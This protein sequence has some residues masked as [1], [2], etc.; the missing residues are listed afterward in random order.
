MID[1][2]KE[3]V[4]KVATTRVEVGTVTELDGTVSALCEGEIGYDTAK[5]I[6]FNNN[7]YQKVKCPHC[8]WSQFEGGESV[9][10]TPCYN[11]NSTG[12]NYIPL[13]EVEK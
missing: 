13:D 3:L 10:M 6:L 5:Q 12:Y 4:E 9:G 8:G 11:C 7:L 2:V 1:K